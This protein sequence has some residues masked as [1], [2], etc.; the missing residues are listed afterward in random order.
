[1]TLPEVPKPDMG[2]SPE[3]LNALS[4]ALNKL[5]AMSESEL[6]WCFSNS[7]GDVRQFIEETGD[8]KQKST[9]LRHDTLDN[10]GK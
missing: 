3:V 6:S 1:M 8:F 10:R 9:I 7:K 5:D 4:S 2:N